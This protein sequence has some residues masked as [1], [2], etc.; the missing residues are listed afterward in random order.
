MSLFTT[1]LLSRWDRLRLR[2]LPRRRETLD[3]RLFLAINRLPHP[4]AG[5]QQLSLL[6]DLGKGVGWVG[7]GCWLALRDGRRGRVA[8]LASTAAMLAAVGLV[9]GPL[10]AVFRRRRPFRH[11]LAVVVGPRPADSSFPSGH[12]AGSFAA[13]SALAAFY[14]EDRPIVLGLAAAVGFSRIYL[15]HHFPSDVLVGA[16]L[17]LLLGRAASSLISGKAVPSSEG[18]E[19]RP[20]RGS[21]PSAAD[22]R[23]A[24][25]AARPAPAP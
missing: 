3:A 17:G 2:L 23:G 14:P 21:T 22:G 7:A 12:S 18:R 20:A 13:A 24:L 5:D 19:D 10:K 6:S 8:A 4:K 16:G 15:G 25:V 9:Q 11:R 1:P